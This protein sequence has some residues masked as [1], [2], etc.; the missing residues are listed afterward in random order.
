MGLLMG[1]YV[2]ALAA[3]SEG[4]VSAAQETRS[5]DAARRVWNS[6]MMGLWRSC[7]CD[8]GMPRER[9][10]SRLGLSGVGFSTARGLWRWWNGEN[11]SEI[12]LD[13]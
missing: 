2:S 9:S 7:L 13:G 3:G 8:G 6:F 4:V 1:P 12:S 11:R 5:V 10:Y